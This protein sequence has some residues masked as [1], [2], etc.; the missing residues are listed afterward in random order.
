VYKLRGLQ[1][2]CVYR[3]VKW[4]KIVQSLTTAVASGG[5]HC[6]RP[7]LLFPRLKSVMPRPRRNFP[8]P[9][10]PPLR[11]TA[12]DQGNRP[13]SRCFSVVTENPPTSPSLPA[14]ILLRT[15]EPHCGRRDSRARLGHTLAIDP[16]IDTRPPK[17]ARDFFLSFFFFI[18]FPEL[19]GRRSESLISIALFRPVRTIFQP[20]KPRLAPPTP[21]HSTAS[22]TPALAWPWVSLRC[23]S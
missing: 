18:F 11:N 2:R 23:I 9:F 10:S 8:S 13:V 5:F 1:R 20:P 19:A 6:W 16:A 12:A 3:G 17:Q 21:L 14:R 22:P 4:E 7:K 15:G